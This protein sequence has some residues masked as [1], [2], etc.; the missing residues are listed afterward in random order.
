[1]ANVK[2]PRGK[3][4]SEGNSAEMRQTRKGNQWYFGMKVQVGTDTRGLVH[5]VTTTDAAQAD[6][7]QLP[8]LLHGAETTLYGDKAYYK[9]EDKFHWE[10]NGDT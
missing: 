9:A 5:T 1:M 6:I 8:A 4:R 10:C 2:L 7:T 3:S